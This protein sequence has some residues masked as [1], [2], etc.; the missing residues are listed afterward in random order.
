M[1]PIAGKML[2]AQLSFGKNFSTLWY[3]SA[4]GE[5]Q[6]SGFQEAPDVADTDE[7]P[8]FKIFKSKPHGLIGIVKFL[9]TLPGSPFQSQVGQGAANLV[10]VD[11]I[12]PFIG[13]ASRGVFHS[14]PRTVSATMPANSL[15][16]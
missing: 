7:A 2:R 16:R 6:L 10:A 13:T 4:K 9:R 15:I 8:T 11:T 14:A 12:A 1:A 3:F 5:I